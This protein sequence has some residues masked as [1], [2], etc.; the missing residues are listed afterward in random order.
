MTPNE[1]RIGNWLTNFLDEEFQVNGNTIAYWGLDEFPD[2][3]PIL[4]TEERLLKFG[5]NKSFLDND[6]CRCWDYELN[7][8]HLHGMGDNIFTFMT[9]KINYVH[10]LQNVF[11]VLTGEELTFKPN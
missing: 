6:Q 7:E 8:F 4:L 9:R 1:L 11:F 3:K 5:F 10:Q 2:P